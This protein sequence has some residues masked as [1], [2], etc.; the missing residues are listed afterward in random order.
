MIPIQ[1]AQIPLTEKGL[2]SLNIDNL[3][4]QSLGGIIDLLGGELQFGVGRDEEGRG[5]GF[6]FKKQFAD[7]GRIGFSKGSGLKT[8]LNFLNENNPVQAY[9]K[10]LESIKTRMKQGKEAEVAGEVIPIAAGGALI[11]N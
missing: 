3:D 7:G 10:Y 9:K 2:L 1:G 4:K 6:T 8:I 11:T 5:A